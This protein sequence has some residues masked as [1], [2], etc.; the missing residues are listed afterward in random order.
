M[1]GGVS[2]RPLLPGVAFKPAATLEKILE[3]QA[4]MFALIVLR[5]K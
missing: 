2:M 1:S 5:R 4:G 3:T